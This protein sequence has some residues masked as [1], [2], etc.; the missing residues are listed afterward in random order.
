M[1]VLRERK[2]KLGTQS[3]KLQS[4]S[5]QGPVSPLCSL[6]LV[7][8]YLDRKFFSFRKPNASI[9]KSRVNYE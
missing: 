4:N 9:S 6:I 3:Y 7:L 8:L 5:C 1:K 2:E